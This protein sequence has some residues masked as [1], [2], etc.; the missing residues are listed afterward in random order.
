MIFDFPPGATDFANAPKAQL[1]PGIEP[2]PLDPHFGMSSNLNSSLNSPRATQVLSA[3]YGGSLRSRPHRPNLPGDLPPQST[4]AHDSMPLS[5]AGPL[6]HGAPVLSRDVPMGVQPSYSY[7]GAMGGGEVVQPSFQFSS[8]AP[9][10]GFGDSGR[11][12]RPGFMGE[13]VVDSVAEEAPAEGLARR[14][15][16]EMPEIDQDEL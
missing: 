1:S 13:G 7:G 9:A 2:S 8:R 10:G 16:E 15:D 3:S 4:G 14:A 6:S 11:Y 12:E 5:R